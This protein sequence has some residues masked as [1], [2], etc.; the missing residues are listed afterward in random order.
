MSLPFCA[1]ARGRGTNG[2]LGW[3]GNVIGGINQRKGTIVDTEIRDDEFTL[4]CEVP[5]NDMFGCE[6]FARGQPGGRALPARKE[7]GLIALPA[8][9][10]F[11]TPWHDPGQGR[12]HYGV[13]PPLARFAERPEGHDRGSQGL[14]RQEVISLATRFPVTSR[15]I[16]P[17][18][19]FTC[20]IPLWP[21]ALRPWRIS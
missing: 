15:F 11:S 12:V 4:L 17:P 3:T 16:R 5:L 6:S 14:C 19:R 1:V 20:L 10:C 21:H 2:A 13:H 18:C 9:R 7:Q 8:R